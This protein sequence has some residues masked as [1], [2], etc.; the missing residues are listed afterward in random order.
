MEGGKWCRAEEEGY[1][2]TFDGQRWESSVTCIGV[3]G[4]GPPCFFFKYIP[5][6]PPEKKIRE[7]KAWY[8][9][10]DCGQFH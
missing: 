7:G 5:G 1:M 6:L 2:S 8:D 10:T 4:N 9:V 3:A